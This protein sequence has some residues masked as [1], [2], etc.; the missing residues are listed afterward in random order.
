VK[1]GSY[2][3]IGLPLLLKIV[4]SLPSSLRYDKKIFDLAV[5]GVRV[6]ALLIN[7][8]PRIVLIKRILRFAGI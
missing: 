1:N 2:W 5:L 8:L 6:D 7:F 3:R 4:H